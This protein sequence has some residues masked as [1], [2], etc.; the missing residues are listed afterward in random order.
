MLLLV[1]LAI[2]V[3]ALEPMAENRARHRRG[4]CDKRDQKNSNCRAFHTHL[5]RVPLQ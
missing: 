4:A 1:A 2:V 5:L 3:V